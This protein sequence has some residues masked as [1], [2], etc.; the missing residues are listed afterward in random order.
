[1][2]FERRTK[3]PFADKSEVA[4]YI[5]AATRDETLVHAVTIALR[6][7]FDPGSCD[8]KHLGS[9]EELKAVIR[10]RVAALGSPQL[11]E[12]TRQFCRLIIDSR[13]SK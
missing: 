12:L 1:M 10:E 11:E 9:A 3:I 8:M 13:R 4:R 2:F 6:M 5:F 7:K